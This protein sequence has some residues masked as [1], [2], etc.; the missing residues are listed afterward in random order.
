MLSLAAHKH[1]A[2]HTRR[3]ADMRLVEAPSGVV[4]REARGEGGKGQ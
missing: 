4:G 2:N 1:A 3:N